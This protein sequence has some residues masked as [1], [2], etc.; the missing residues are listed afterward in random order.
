MV[1]DPL[2]LAVTLAVDRKTYGAL[3]CSYVTGQGKETR[4]ALELVDD[5]VHMRSHQLDPIFKST[6]SNHY[7]AIEVCRCCDPQSLKS[8]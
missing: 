2:A 6:T 5:G 7:Y 3:E 8:C 1:M 4:E